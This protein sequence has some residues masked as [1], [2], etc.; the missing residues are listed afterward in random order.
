MALIMLKKNYPQSV[1]PFLLILFLC[2]LSF[3]FVSIGLLKLYQYLYNSKKFRIRKILIK[4][5]NNEIEDCVDKIIG[6]VLTQMNQNILFLDKSFLIVMIK[7]NPWI[8]SVNIER[9]LPDTLVIKVKKKVPTSL[10]LINNSLFY[11]D[12]NANIFKIKEKNDPFYDLPVITGIDPRKDNFAELLKKINHIILHIGKIKFLDVSEFHID[13]YG[14]L[15]LYLS[16]PK[17]DILFSYHLRNED[18]KNVE[19]KIQRLKKILNYFSN[20]DQIKIM[21][22]DI[23]CIQDGAVVSFEEI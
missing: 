11:V 14:D 2:V 20:Y 16:H 13:K 3:F 6:H 8:K 15:H 1:R 7:M 5:G 17:I 9:K 22:I 19:K 23:D 10:I 12:S 18:N 21:H 4:G